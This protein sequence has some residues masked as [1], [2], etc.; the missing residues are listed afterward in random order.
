MTTGDLLLAIFLIVAGIAMTF[1]TRK[2]VNLYQIIFIGLVKLN[3]KINKI[4][5]KPLENF[6]NKLHSAL[7]AFVH[8]PLFLSFLK[9]SFLMIGIVWLLIG[10][11]FLIFLILQ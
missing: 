11:T 9:I 7:I 3:R 4:Y 5:P 10:I 8:N 1:F 6:M 2:V